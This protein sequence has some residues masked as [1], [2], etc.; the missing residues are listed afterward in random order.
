MTTPTA[1]KPTAAEVL[2]VADIGLDA[3]AALLARYG[4]RLHRV[5]AGAAI[6]GSFWGEPEAGII[7]CD[8]YVRDDTPVHSLLHEAGHLIVLPAEK[9]AAVHTDA[10]DS[11]E[12]EDATCY[13]QILLAE[14]L[15][16]VGSARL[17]AD[18]DSWGYTYRLGST[19]AWFEQDAE[20]AR[21]WLD[22]RGLL[23]A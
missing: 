5:G 7:G 19:R 17:M 23:P 18:M 15:P 1:A 10:T 9:R 20:N 16:G 3:P 8:V 11:V 4:L 14:Q 21:S 6:P 2:R 13:L 12:E 22:A